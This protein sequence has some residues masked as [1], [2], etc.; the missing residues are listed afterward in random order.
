MQTADFGKKEDSP[1]KVLEDIRKARRDPK[2][3]RPPAVPH[4]EAYD[5]STAPTSWP[6]TPRRTPPGSPSPS[7]PQ[8]REGQEGHPQAARAGKKSAAAVST[9]PE[10]P[11]AKKTTPEK[12]KA[13]GGAFAPVR[14][15]FTHRNQKQEKPANSTCCRRTRAVAKGT[16]LSAPPAPTG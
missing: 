7:P 8:P 1:T 12:P 15:L 5:C 9:T 14:N 10:Q 13:P 16:D 2:V 6:V 4:S 11:V 3:L